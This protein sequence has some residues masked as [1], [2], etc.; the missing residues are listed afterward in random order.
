MP[1]LLGHYNLRAKKLEL[2]SDRFT[3]GLNKTLI[4]I[5]ENNAQVRLELYYGKA[6]QDIAT[7]I[8]SVAHHFKKKHIKSGQ[9]QYSEL[10]DLVL[11]LDSPE[12]YRTATSH[13]AEGG[14]QIDYDPI[15][16]IIDAAKKGYFSYL[17]LQNEFSR[18]VRR[19]NKHIS[20]DMVFS[21]KL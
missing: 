16:R 5:V 11:R 9:P 12:V 18:Y 19:A 1:T 21:K 15:K 14:Y 8:L 10:C 17:L 7:H 13:A 4:G 20:M 6:D 3:I 2:P